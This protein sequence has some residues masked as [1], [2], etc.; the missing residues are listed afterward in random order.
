[1][2]T[3]AYNRFLTAARFAPAV[4]AVFFALAPAVLAVLFVLASC[5]K[6]TVYDPGS[7]QPGSGQAEDGLRVISL[8]YAA[9]TKSSSRP[10]SLRP[11]EQRHAGLDPAS[12]PSLPT[13][14]SLTGLLPA[15]EAGDVIKVSNGEA[16]EDCTVAVQGGEPFITTS[17]SG[18]LDAVFPA[19]AAILDGQSISG[20]RVPGVQDGNPVSTIIATAAIPDGSVTA[21][22]RVAVSVLKISLPSGTRRLTVKSLRP[23][24]NGIARTGDAAEINTDGATSDER[25]VVTVGDGSTDLPETV[26]VAVKS[27]AR[28]CDL[29][30]DAVSAAAGHGSMKGIPEYNN[31]SAANPSAP[32]ILYTVSGSNW[33]E[34]VTIAGLKWATMNVGASSATDGGE[35]FQWGE[36][37]GHKYVGDAW[38]NF[39]ADNPDPIRYTGG[40]NAA[41]CFDVDNNHNTPYYSGSTPVKYTAAGS[42]LE[43]CDDAANFNWGGSWRMPAKSEIEALWSAGHSRSSDVWTMGTSPNQIQFGIRGYANRLGLLSTNS[44]ASVWSSTLDLNN[45]RGCRLCL[46]SSTGSVSGSSSDPRVVG[47]GIRPVSD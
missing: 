40:W 19:T 23:I 27:G 24:D 43:L 11:A 31:P 39:P 44:C 8:S 6:E 13:K 4:L 46:D 36:I 34:Y 25:L 16:T 12:L 1:M 18:A 47:H 5:S 35:Y 22:F 29:S 33:H 42:V 10:A 30:F 20:I 37:V 26:H 28:F 32:G 7:G 45:I 2:K 21:A 14:A 3:T 9:P 15:F 41:L 17:L 38:T